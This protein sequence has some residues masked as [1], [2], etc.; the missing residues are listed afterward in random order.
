MIISIK[1]EYL[2][3]YNR[4]QIICISLVSLINDISTFVGYLMPKPQ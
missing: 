4:V 1:S 3:P 2:K